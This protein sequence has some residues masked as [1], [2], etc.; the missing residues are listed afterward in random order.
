M[1]RSEEWAQINVHGVAWLGYNLKS[2]ASPSRHPDA[3]TQGLGAILALLARWPSLP[4]RL[5]ILESDQLHEW[6]QLLRD[7]RGGLDHVSRSTAGC[8]ARPP[9]DLQVESLSARCSS[10]EVCQ[11]AA[12]SLPGLSRVNLHISDLQLDEQHVDQLL[13]CLAP[14][15]ELCPRLLEMHLF[16]I[17][18]CPKKVAA[19]LAHDQLR[20]WAP[21]ICVFAINDDPPAPFTPN[22]FFTVFA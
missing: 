17:R 22:R 11:E 14:F 9:A 12:R 19:F 10:N 8:S 2:E 3:A 6:V 4:L 1:F 16:F 21:K 5:R 13:G 7:L 18:S 20:R 15:V